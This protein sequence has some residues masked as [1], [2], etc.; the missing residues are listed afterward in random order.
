[1]NIVS[2]I[3]NQA[4]A[5]LVAIR[6][7]GILITFDSLFAGVDEIRSRLLE[8]PCFGKGKIPRVGVIFPN[9]QA[10]ITAALA[11]LDA[12]ACFVPIPDELTES[13]RD[14]LIATTALDCLVRADDA[15]FPLPLEFGNASLKRF[16]ENEPEFPVDRFEALNPAFIRFSSGTTGDS[17]GVVLSHESLLARILA[18]NE[19]LKLSAGDKVLW[20]L[21]MAHHFAVTII[22]YL[23]HG[24]TTVL[25]TSNRPDLLF[26]QPEAFAEIAKYLTSSEAN[27]EVHFNTTCLGI[28]QERDDSF[29][30]STEEKT[31]HCRAIIDTSADAIVAESLGA[32]RLSAPPEKLQRAAFIFSMKNVDSTAVEENFRMRLALEIVRAVASGELPLPALGTACRASTVQGEIFF[33]TD[34]D[35]APTEELLET[36]RFLS[37][38][39]AGFLRSRFPEYT[40][41][42]GPFPAAE[43]G[44]RE[45]YRW[46][47]EYTL[48]ADDLVNATKFPDTIAHAT[49]PMELREDTRGSKLCFFAKPIP[50]NIPLRSLRS[51]EIPGVFFAGRCISAT[52]EA[53]ASVR[54]MGTCFATGQA[55]GI[56]VSKFVSK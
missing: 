1:V 8:L 42:T 24:V 19:G 47:G 44:T 18:A 12:G 48:T 13:E 53:L 56:E 49:W 46:L 3:R 10:Y 25:E 35:P 20:T 36:G 14:S 43:P 32:T 40:C 33:T 23:Y 51:T 16:R 6:G 31:I 7:Q 41:A 11:V 38:E 27:L 29:L 15:G 28:P 17:K 22:L 45:S 39:L 30:V 37:E 21:P 34:L 2:E 50:A 52:H 5:D 55:A 26:Q 4:H 54:V 9:G